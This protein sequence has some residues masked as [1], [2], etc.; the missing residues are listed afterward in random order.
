MAQ[1]IKLWS[2]ENDRLRERRRRSLDFEER[3]EGWISADPTIVSRE[4]MIGGLHV[5]TGFGGV[6]DLLGLEESGDLVVLNVKR[7][8][9]PRDVTAQALD[10]AAWAQG[11]S[12][13]EVTAIADSY[14]AAKGPLDDAFQHYFG[15]EI[16]DSLN[17][18]HRI[19][20]VAAE[21]DPSSER[22]IR[23]LS[24]GHGVD[25]NAVSFQQF[26][27]A[28]GSETLARVFLM[29]PAQVRYRAK[30]RSAG[31]RRRPTTPEELQE[32][33]DSRGAGE[34]YRNFIAKLGVFPNRSTSRNA[35]QF[36]ATF[37]D[38][39]KV[40]LSL[41]PE[42]SSARD[43]VHFELYTTRL[44]K[45]F[46]LDSHKVLHLLPA[47]RQPWE[48]SQPPPEDQKGMSGFFANQEEVDR[49]VGGLKP[50]SVE[51]LSFRTPRST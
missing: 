18:S 50:R 7:E 13:E 31:K 5:K 44:G 8:S 34:L 51:P 41:T 19:L 12:N 39:R 26:E 47:N 22:I 32:T 29:D 49:F 2:I 48:S 28:D 21:L 16:P 45:H 10:Y 43:G 27:L 30:T 11:L 9:S 14:L 24:E 3:L 25:I 33:A 23:F 36:L 40:I 17:D 38:K 35:M 42:K 37:D 6:V 4:L 1:D 15:K 46:E 20:I